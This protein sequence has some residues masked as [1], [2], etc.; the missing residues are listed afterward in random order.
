MHRL[1]SIKAREAAKA[2]ARKRK[3]MEAEQSAR[4]NT[5]ANTLGRIMQQ[6]GDESDIP[7]YKRVR[8][9]VEELRL[10]LREKVKDKI[11]T[12]IKFEIEHAK[13]P[14]EQDKEKE[15]D[16]DEENKLLQLEEPDDAFADD[17]YYMEDE[18]VVL[19]E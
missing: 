6:R 14:K 3:K 1:Q 8:M 15:Q 5:V 12:V 10:D 7:H 4:K 2:E 17:D 13:K 16:S 18:S 11:D 9:A 19:T